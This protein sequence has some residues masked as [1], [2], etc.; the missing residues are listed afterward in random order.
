MA[1]KNEQATPANV[2]PS[3][4]RTLIEGQYTLLDVRCDLRSLRTARF[5]SP[6]C[7]Q[8]PAG[9]GTCRRIAALPCGIPA[10]CP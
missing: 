8:L 10:G 5:N 7:P 6:V 9:G 1:D 3:E 2:P 4:A